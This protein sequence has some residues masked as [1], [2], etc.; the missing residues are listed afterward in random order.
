MDVCSFWSSA[1]KRWYFNN[2]HPLNE[3]LEP[4]VLEEE[5]DF[6]LDQAGSI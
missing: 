1:W 2:G 5:V 4:R 3:A 6:I